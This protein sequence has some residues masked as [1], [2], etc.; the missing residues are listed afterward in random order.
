MLLQHD[1]NGPEIE[2]LACNLTASSTP[3]GGPAA[4]HA[5][6]SAVRLSRANDCTSMAA[7]AA[8]TWCIGGAVR[9]SYR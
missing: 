7:K 8:A 4:A 3:P 9:P 5:D 2:V 6:R 1:R